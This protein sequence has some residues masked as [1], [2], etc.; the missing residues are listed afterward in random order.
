MADHKLELPG[1]SPNF[2]DLPIAEQFV[3]WAARVWVKSNQET[4]TLHLNL[5]DGFRAAE[6]EEGY[7]M[8][9][10]IMTLLSTRAS[11]KVYFHLKCCTGITN[12][13]HA[14]LGVIAEFQTGADA[15]AHM[16]LR[17]WLPSPAACEAGREFKNYATLLKANGLHIRER[18]WFPAGGDQFSLPSSPLPTVH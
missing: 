11:R 6:I 13:E 7:L 15:N 17:D 5:R 1:S 4:P 3:L 2:P 14:F 10:R 9:D 18:Q 8:L 16:I 12:H